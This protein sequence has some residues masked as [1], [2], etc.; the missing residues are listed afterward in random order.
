MRHYVLF[1]ITTLV[2]SANS[3]AFNSRTL[4]EVVKASG[5]PEKGYYGYQFENGERRNDGYTCRR[6]EPKEVQKIFN[7]EILLQGRSCTVK[8]EREILKPI[9]QTR[10]YP[11]TGEPYRQ[12]IGSHGNS[13][14]LRF[15]DKNGTPNRP[16]GGLPDSSV[17][18]L[19]NPLS[20]RHN[21]SGLVICANNS[22]KFIFHCPVEY[23][24]NEHPNLFFGEF[25]GTSSFKLKAV[26]LFWARANQV[27]TL[28]PFAGPTQLKG[29]RLVTDKLCN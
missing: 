20:H 24:I 4:K 26:M 28:F 27:P 8:S 15:Y 21:S 11:D 14:D 2:L 25:E 3:F 23:K 29:G 5:C 13:Y 18:A 6:A 16:S 22:R 1:T 9:V 10:Y 17:Y 12:T 19:N 7:N